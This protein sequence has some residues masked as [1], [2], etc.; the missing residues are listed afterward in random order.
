MCETEE[1]SAQFKAQLSL[2]LEAN[3]DVALQ[4]ILRALHI[5]R[6]QTWFLRCRVWLYRGAWQV[7]TAS[8]FFTHASTQL[9]V[10]SSACG[11]VRPRLAALR[12]LAGEH[13]RPCSI[14]RRH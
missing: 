1:Q 6:T 12:R 9:V 8:P 2:W 11:F 13:G 3:V 10:S 7:C 5:V 14:V 4:A